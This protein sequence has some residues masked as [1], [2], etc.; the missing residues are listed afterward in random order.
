M[1]VQDFIWNSR[2]LLHLRIKIPVV[3]DF[4]AELSVPISFR[5]SE[6]LVF[7]GIS[8]S[9]PIDFYFLAALRDR[10]LRIYDYSIILG[11]SGEGT[12]L[13]GKC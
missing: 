1:R 6:A 7:L 4:L 13:R 10:I 9:P 12:F 3:Y 5:V 2:T 8:R 11:G